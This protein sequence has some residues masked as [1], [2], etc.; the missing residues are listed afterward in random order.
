[1]SLLRNEVKKVEEIKQ[2]EA[3]KVEDVI[4]KLEERKVDRNVNS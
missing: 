2:K 3:M 4:K 1:M